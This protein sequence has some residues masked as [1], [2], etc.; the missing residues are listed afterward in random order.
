M[1]RT[2]IN[3]VKKQKVFEQNKNEEAFLDIDTVSFYSPLAPDKLSHVPSLGK[4]NEKAAEIRVEISESGKYVT[5]K[6][7]LYLLLKFYKCKHLGQFGLTHATHLETI[8]DL[9]RYQR[10]IDSFILEYNLTI[11]YATYHELEQ[12]L[13]KYFNIS[14]YSE[15]NVG[16]LCENKLVRELFKLP[17]YV[18]I[19]DLN[20]NQISYLDLFRHLRKYLDEKQ[21]WPIKNIQ[22]NDFEYYL[23]EKINL[24]DYIPV[25]VNSIG[26]MIGVMKNVILSRFQFVF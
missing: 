5:W 10:K 14:K 4:L 20:E 1:P 25:R 8:N 6:E 2:N 7:I 16:P 13:C 24:K 21:L 15:L 26:I 18:K 17:E 23:M 11:S 19:D 9:I 22:I 12:S 3:E